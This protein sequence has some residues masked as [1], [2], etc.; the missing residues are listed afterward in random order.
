[1]NPKFRPARVRPSG[2]GHAVRGKKASLVNWKVPV[3]ESSSA[4]PR[5]VARSTYAASDAVSER[6]PGCG[7]HGSVALSATQCR[8]V[9]TARPPRLVGYVDTPACADVQTLTREESPTGP[10]SFTSEAFF[11]LDGV[12]APGV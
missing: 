9:G 1:V 4:R 3:G 2:A 12:P 6:R 11:P 7:G 8:D 10:S 5:A